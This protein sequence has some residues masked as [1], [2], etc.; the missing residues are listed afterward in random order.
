MAV[1]SSVDML[2]AA[3][4]S[5][6]PWNRDGLPVTMATLPSRSGIWSL[7]ILSVVISVA[8]NVSDKGIMSG[9]ACAH[10]TAHNRVLFLKK[11]SHDSLE[12]EAEHF[13]NCRQQ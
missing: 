11:D 5:L 3:S 10:G 8:E 1:V 12:D 4:D 2:P 13:S 6:R 9:T 7:L